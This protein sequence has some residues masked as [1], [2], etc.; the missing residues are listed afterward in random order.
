MYRKVVD[1]FV[2]RIAGFFGVPG[3]LRKHGHDG[4]VVLSCQWF[5]LKIE[6][7]SAGG[8]TVAIREDNDREYADQKGKAFV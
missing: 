2:L 4:I 6:A 5:V 1:G 3:R 8:R 7:T